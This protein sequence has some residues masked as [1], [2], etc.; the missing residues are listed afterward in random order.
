M[1]P[2]FNSIRKLNSNQEA[3]LSDSYFWEL[4]RI[5]DAF[6]RM[7]LNSFCARTVIIDV[8]VRVHNYRTLRLSILRGI[9]LSIIRSIL[10]ARSPQTTARSSD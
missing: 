9:G 2:L 7:H 3:Y 1:T 6:V 8:C 10:R 4:G 5:F